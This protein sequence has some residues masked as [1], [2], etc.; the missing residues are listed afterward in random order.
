MHLDAIISL[1]IN[2]EN[3]KL[4]R[5]YSAKVFQLKLTLK[6]LRLFDYA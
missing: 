6:S 2:R 5:D 1:L 4:N 3:R